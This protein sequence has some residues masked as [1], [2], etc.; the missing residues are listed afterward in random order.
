LQIQLKQREKKLLAVLAAVMVIFVLVVYVVDPFLARQE[1]IRQELTTKLHLLQK[2]REK[3]TQIGWLENQIV[4]LKEFIKISDGQMLPGK[5]PSLAAAELQKL[6]KNIARSSNV[7]I[8][9]EKIIPSIDLGQYEQIP[10]QV[11]FV[12]NA[13]ALKEILYRIEHHSRLLLIPVM[14][15]KVTSAK[16]PKE[17]ETTLVVAGLIRSG[18]KE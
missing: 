4:E 5:K 13:T 8:R 15:V 1:E 14:K 18:M 17:T 7:N 16:S 6:L 10:V 2:N 12:S 9:Q 11:T 3:V